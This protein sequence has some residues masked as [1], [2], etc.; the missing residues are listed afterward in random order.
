[1]TRASASKAASAKQRLVADLE[2]R[3]YLRII[4]DWYGCDAGEYAEMLA[5]ALRDR[6]CARRTYY[7]LVEEIEQQCSV[8]ADVYLR[9]GSVSASSPA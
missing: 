2:L 5:A 3:R 1:M 6:E 8:T 9:W 7:A 4:A